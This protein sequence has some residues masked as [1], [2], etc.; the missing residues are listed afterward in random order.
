MLLNPGG[1][2]LTIGCTQCHDH[3]FD[4]ITQKEYYGLYAYFN[5]CS[6]TGQLKYGCAMKKMIGGKLYIE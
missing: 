2:G 4:P 5:Q 6:E 1:H 3:K